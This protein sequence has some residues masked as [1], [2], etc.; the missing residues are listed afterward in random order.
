[1]LLHPARAYTRDH[2][3]YAIPDHYTEGAIPLA[4]LAR[5]GQDRASTDVA[6]ETSFIAA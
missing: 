4:S 2:L 5:T 3:M 6:A 1:M